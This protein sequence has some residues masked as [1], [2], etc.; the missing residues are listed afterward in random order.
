MKI[1]FQWKPW[2]WLSELR[3]LRTL[4]EFHD[5]VSEATEELRSL[6]KT[7]AHLEGCNQELRAALDEANDRLA[8]V[9]Q[10][11]PALVTETDQKRANLT[12]LMVLAGAGEHPVWKVVLSY[13]DEHARNE[14]QVA[15]G[16][17]LSDGDRH[18]A[19]GRAGGALDFAA[20]L[21]D[22]RAKAE[23]E[24]RKLKTAG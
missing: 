6:R 4:E 17:N 21:R 11:T 14:E 24:A 18:Y 13:A 10:R 3:E 9:Y 22:L 1:S 12:R 23:Q 15:L 2:R 16:P 20:A 5:Q 19:A 8:A 7:V